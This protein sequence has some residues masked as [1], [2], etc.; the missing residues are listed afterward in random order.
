[1]PAK[2]VLT[3][4]LRLSL[5][6]PERSSDSR[7]STIRIY[8]VKLRLHRADR[9]PPPGAMASHLLMYQP[10]R[11]FGALRDDIFQSLERGAHD[12]SRFAFT[13]LARD[14]QQ[15]T[16]GLRIRI[17]I[18]SRGRIATRPSASSST[19]STRTPS[20]ALMISPV[21]GFYDSR[22]AC[23]SLLGLSDDELVDHPRNT[24]GLCRK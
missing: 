3:R 14:Q 13:Y 12:A 20:R 11:S 7:V 16:R 17:R 23:V 8:L 15:S 21:S 22:P 1:V 24:L 10:L 5:K 2:R 19:T 9:N 6:T 4:P 18:R